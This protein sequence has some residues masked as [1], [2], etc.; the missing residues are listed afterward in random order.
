MSKWVSY[1]Y[2]PRNDPERLQVR[3]AESKLFREQLPLVLANADRILATARYFY[4]QFDDA[5][6]SAIWLSGG[7][8]IPLGALLLLWRRG[9]MVFECPECRGRFHAV[10]MCG[11]IL[12]GS[13]S[14]AT[15]HPDGPTISATCA[16]SR[17]VPAPMSSTHSPLAMFRSEINCLPCSK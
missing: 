13:G 4:C 7:G 15:T 1:G 2:A 11:S 9:H 8:P 12:S 17:P 6:L 5:Y 14:I 16:A 10:G 3:Q